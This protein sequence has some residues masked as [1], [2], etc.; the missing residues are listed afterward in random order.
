[1]GCTLAACRIQD[2]ETAKR[3]AA[4]LPP[5]KDGAALLVQAKKVCLA[6]KV[7]L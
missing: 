2:A 4:A 6:N 1:M 7:G 5:S 3:Y